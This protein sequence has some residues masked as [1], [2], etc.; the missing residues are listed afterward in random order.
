MKINEN[1]CPWQA[2]EHKKPTVSR[3]YCEKTGLLMQPGVL[4]VAKDAARFEV[5]NRKIDECHCM[6]L[7]VHQYCLGS[8]LFLFWLEEWKPNCLNIVLSLEH[9][10]SVNTC[11]ICAR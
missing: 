11:L 9:Y 5:G 4:V 1:G 7:R 8:C 10:A 6:V 3:H 2:K